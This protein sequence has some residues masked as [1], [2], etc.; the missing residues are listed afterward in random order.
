MAATPKSRNY[1]D[2]DLAIKVAVIAEN[3]TAT[4]TAIAAIQAAIQE[5]QRAQSEAQ[6]AQYQDMKELRIELV[7]ILDNNEQRIRGCEIKG[8]QLE[9]NLK[10][11]TG[12][13]AGIQLVVA[14]VGAWLASV[15]G[16]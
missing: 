5:G 15:T 16:K 4:Q 2:S 3:I 13:F 9:A 7:R 8:G 1:D 12:V 14:G 10:T 11:M 6:K